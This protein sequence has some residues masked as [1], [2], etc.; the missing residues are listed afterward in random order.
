[1]ET[2][3]GEAREL[4]HELLGELPE[5]WQHTAGVARCAEAVAGTVPIGDVPV[6]LAAAW[7][8]DIGYAPPLHDSGFHPL[9]GA[10]HLLARN[11]PIRL[12][13]LVAHHSEA[14]CV[15][16]R[17]GLGAALAAFPRENSPVTD[18]LTYADQSVG[19]YGRP[20]T[21]DERLDDMLRRHGPASPNAAAHAERAPRLRAAVQRVQERLAGTGPAA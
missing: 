14:R 8:H 6:L 15:A 13:G 19:P 16:D 20:M 21:F 3:V 2:D 10:R 11:W 9:D 7:L 17:R 1:M 12:A 18:A 4:A 5:R